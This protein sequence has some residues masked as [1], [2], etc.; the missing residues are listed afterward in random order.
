MSKTSEKL[1]EAGF[2]L[3]QL[4]ANY[5]VHPALLYFT[6][7]FIS[8]ARSV[9]W[10]MRNE[11]HDIEGW[12]SWYESMRPTQNEDVLLK[13]INT[14]GV[15]TE[16]QAPLK[17]NLRVDFVIPIPPGRDIEEVRHLLENY[18]NKALQVSAE[19]VDEGSENRE[20][21]VTENGLKFTGKAEKVYIVLEDLADEDALEQCKKYYA[22][23]EKLVSECEE[24]F[25]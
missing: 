12:E 16:K 19:M 10:I 18:R 24:R 1:D 3:K 23:L 13:Q 14:E 9:L 20:F 25:G 5:F 7:A 22:I 17:A 6:S 21:E 2:F 4:E 15:R 11:Y 8:S